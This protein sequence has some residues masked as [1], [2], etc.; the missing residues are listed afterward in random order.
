M[1]DNSKICGECDRSAQHLL[2][3]LKKAVQRYYFDHN[4]T[5]PV[6]PEVLEAML[7]VLTEA[8]GNPSSI[9]HYGQ[10]ARAR[11]DHARRQVAR[12]L[13]C[14]DTEIVFT[15]GGTESDNLAILGIGGHVVTT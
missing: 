15:S 3:K 11:L 1:I 2:L 4:A 14:S 8:F 5:T 12:L 6:S 10:E 9:H 13:H 7:P